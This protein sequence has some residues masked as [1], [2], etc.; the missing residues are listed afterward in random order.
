[1]RISVS[2]DQLSPAQMEWLT[3]HLPADRQFQA[4][5]IRLCATFSMPSGETLHRECEVSE[6]VRIIRELHLVGLMIE[7]REMPAPAAVPGVMWGAYPRNAYEE[8][9]RGWSGL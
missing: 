8:I 1:M 3:A 5:D 6:W 2:A 7:V 9:Q 4:G